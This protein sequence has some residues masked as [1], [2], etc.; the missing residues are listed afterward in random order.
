L[1]LLYISVAWLA[2]TFTGSLIQVPAWLL[3]L[4]LPLLICAIFMRSQ[5]RLLITTAF[6]LL[7]LVGSAVRYQ[8]SI[9]T[10]DYTSLQFY[11]GRGTVTVHGTISDSPETRTASMQFHFAADAIRV[12]NRTTAVQGNLLVRL[13]FYRQFKYGEELQLTGK[14]ETAPQFDGFDYRNYL[15][16]QGIY[17]VMDYPQAVVLKSDAG[18]N[19]L[20]MVYYLRSK[21]ADSLSVCIAEPQSS[22]AQAIVLGL[23]GSL[24]ESM[25]QSFYQTGTTHLIAI[26]G[27]NLTI[28]L[29]MLLPLAIRL[30]GRKNRLYIWLSLA[31][32]WLYTLMTGLPPS[33]IRA[34]IMG[35]VFLLAELLGRQRNAMAA[36]AFAAAAMVM[37]QPGVLWDAGFQLSFLSMLGLVMMTPYLVHLIEPSAATSKTKY[38]LWL[39]NSLIIGFGTTLA[40][41]LATWPVTALDFRSF[42]LAGA[43]ATLLAMPSFPAIM[44]TSMASAV[45]GLIWQPLGVLLG[46]VAWL[47][48]GY[49]LLVVNIFSAIPVAYIQNVNIQPWQAILYYLVLIAILADIKHSAAIGAFARGIKSGLISI[50]TGLQSKTLRPYVYAAIALLL[51]SNM[52]VWTALSAMPDDKLHVSVL[53]VGQGES[54]LIRTPNNQKILIDAGPDPESACIALGRSLPFWDRTI[55]LLILTQLQSDHIAG[56]LEL[57][58][59]YSVGQVALP[60]VP[61]ES[62]LSRELSHVLKASGTRVS[63]LSAGQ[64]INMGNNIWLTCL[65]P[66]QQTLKG[67]DDD[68]N[69]NS[70]VLRLTMGRISFLLTSDIGEDAERYIDDSTAGLRSDVLKVAHHGSKYSTS[71]RFLAM[72]NPVAAVISAGA[73]NRFGH[74]SQEVMDRLS[75]RIGPGFTFV[76]MLDGT[77][78]F[79]T[80]GSSL[81]RQCSNLRQPRN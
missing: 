8:S 56:S 67:T 4:A 1:P 6:C 58:H 77:V 62:A 15:A 60:P 30:F 38:V 17:S 2:G 41:T 49:F 81:W 11:N 80:D 27:L 24:P 53:D 26:S 61:A 51:I 52:L 74:P 68:T 33:M 66:P 48:L 78:E 29:G 72:V 75:E 79:T 16:N 45:A 35:S 70:V 42:S 36:M 46:W 65:H 23:R 63:T 7:A 44:L 55:D 40:A 64:Q 22:L 54:I 39:R 57:L 25:V 18:L 37:V 28:I 14:L 34:A 71:D 12:E 43:P 69:N 31:L 59:R 5:R 73:G 3:A 9:Q 32:I 21:L 13:P 20:S 10:V 76:T 19:P 50:W 47:F